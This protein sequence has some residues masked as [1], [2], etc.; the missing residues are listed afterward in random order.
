MPQGVEVQVLSSA[1]MENL[2]ASC[3]QNW[4][5][6]NVPLEEMLRTQTYP[7]FIKFHG[8]PEL[9][10]RDIDTP[11]VTHWYREGT[12]IQPDF[13]NPRFP[14]FPNNALLMEMLGT[15]QAGKSSLIEH[16]LSKQGESS[17]KFIEEPF[18]SIPQGLMSV[19][20]LP[21]EYGE[22]EFLHSFHDRSWFNVFDTQQVKI[23]NWINTVQ[24]LSKGNSKPDDVWIGYRGP[25]DTLCWIYTY[26]CHKIEDEFFVVPEFRE[27]F[28]K[29]AKACIGE[30]CVFSAKSSAIVMMGI[31]QEE[32]IAR[33]RKAGKTYMSYS[34]TPI[35]NELS[36]W[37]GFF[38]R[39]VYPRLRESYGTGLLILD[40]E[41]STDYNVERLKR[42]LLEVRSVIG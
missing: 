42:Y 28:E 35:Y 18:F 22:D 30:M 6:S 23:R 31:S 25:I 14:W 41:R 38:I 5:M 7:L 24:L 8:W 16:F 19:E 27:S 2:F 32:A 9:S 4:L 39:N 15:F 34:E 11:E 40:G 36:A 29:W 1:A 20:M 37:Y 13:S 33:R 17:V 12:E 21:P 3:P 26:A 10:L